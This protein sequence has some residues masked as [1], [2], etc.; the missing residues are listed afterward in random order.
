MTTAGYP[1]ER[2]EA[3]L[4]KARLPLCVRIIPR[5]HIKTPLGV[6]PAD[7]RFSTV[8]DDYRVLY[9]SP[10]FATAFIEVVVRDR[11]VRKR[12][13][14]VILNE[15]TERAWAMITTRPGLTLSLLDLRKDGC[16]LLGAPTDAVNARNHASG[17]SLGRT[18]YSEH[19]DVDGLL[20]S[21]RLTGA[22]VYA[23]FDRAFEKLQVERTGQLPDHPE[24]PAVLHRHHIGLVIMR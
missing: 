16:G 2:I 1:R 11:F 22:D 10:E 23:I 5:R 13:R 20:F 7:S 3:V 6:T 14:E 18:I 9:V 17:R 4:S 21:S 19:K 15:V 24:L 12:R 8:G